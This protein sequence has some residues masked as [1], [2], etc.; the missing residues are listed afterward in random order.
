[1]KLKN[2][3]VTAFAFLG[4]TTSVLYSACVKDAC[5]DL[6]CQNN[7]TCTD[8][9]CSCPTG[10]EGT[11]CESLSVDRFVG[12]YYGV[13]VKTTQEYPTGTL[14]TLYD[15]VVIFA[16]PE[17]NRVGV[18]RFNNAPSTIIHKDTVFGFVNGRYID[19]DSVVKNNY[20]EYTSVVLNTNGLT[21]H[22]EEV[23]QVNDTTT[24]KTIITFTGPRAFK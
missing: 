15:T 4:I 1:M 19:I 17:P 18:V 10:Y 5:A 2:T 22:R 14:P 21:Y 12:T 7:G 24:Y 20:K 3:L 16:N 6:K 9:F 8:G 13:S 11:E 23:T